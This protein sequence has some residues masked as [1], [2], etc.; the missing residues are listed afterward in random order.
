MG[1][2]EYSHRASPFIQSPAHTVK[3]KEKAQ[4][5]FKRFSIENFMHHCFDSVISV[6][7]KKR[8]CG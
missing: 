8:K 4:H 1:K 7:K 6:P 3:V 2:R 5:Y